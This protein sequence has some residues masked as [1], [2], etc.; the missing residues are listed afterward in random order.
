MTTY[1]D[2]QSKRLAETGRLKY[3]TRRQK[4]RELEEE[5][6]AKRKEAMQKDRANGLKVPHS[7]VDHENIVVINDD[8]N[9]V[10]DG[11]ET[12]EE[13]ADISVCDNKSCLYVAKLLQFSENTRPAYYGTWRKKSTHVSG[14]KPFGTD[15]VS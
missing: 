10:D 15:N 8:S 2:E 14:R 1:L 4:R 13:E 9:D 6:A 5:L 7:E 11:E 3:I 12:E